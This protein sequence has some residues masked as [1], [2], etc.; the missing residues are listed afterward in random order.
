MNPKINYTLV[1]AFV[2]V[3]VSLTVGLTLWMSYDQGKTEYLPYVTYFQDSVSGLNERAA[4]KYR[5]VPIGYV[6][7]I[8]LESEPQERVRLELQLQADVLIRTDTVATLQHQGITGLLYLDLESQQQGEPLVTSN[9]RPAVIQSRPSRLI[10]LS[11]LLTSTLHEVSSLASSL[12]QL[13]QQLANLSDQE[14]RD[15][16]LHTLSSLQNL[17]NTAESKLAGIQPED[18][19]QLVISLSQL[20]N[21]ASQVA[22]HLPDNLNQLLLPL[23]QDL[24]HLMQNAGSTNRQLLPLLLQVDQ[25]IQQLNLESRSWIRGNTQQPAG[26]GE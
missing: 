25:L 11:E 13:S 14:M 2:L 24:Q 15:Q 3:F 6:E 21:Q 8:R 18:Y 1:G 5:G 22:E 12:N 4:V 19:Q 23:Q 7:R 26:P 9:A 20:V 16:L 17:M 10:E